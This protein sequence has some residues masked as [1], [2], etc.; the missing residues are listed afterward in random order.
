MMSVGLA[1]C[2]A[3]S[4]QPSTKKAPTPQAV[5]KNSAPNAFFVPSHPTPTPT[6]LPTPTP[7]S[8]TSSPA[9]GT[10]NTAPVT[11]ASGTV[12]RTNVTPLANEEFATASYTLWIPS[13]AST[14]FGVIVWG[15]WCGG[16]D[17]GTGVASGSDA[18][19]GKKYH[20]A[21]LGQSLTH[22]DGTRNCHENYASL[23]SGPAL[24]RALSQFATLSNHAELAKA[25]LVADGMSVT[26]GWV[27]EMIKLYPD[28]VVAGFARGAPTQDNLVQSAIKVPLMLT[29]GEK[30]PFLSGDVTDF[31]QHRALGA[32]WALAT[33]P[34]EG[35]TW[36]SQ[37]TSFLSIYF[38]AVL[39]L[40]LTDTVG[41][42]RSIDTTQEGWLGDNSTHQI[43]A[44]AQYQGNAALKCSWLPDEKSAQAWM[45]M[46]TTAKVS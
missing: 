21:V 2:G 44:V 46:V 14:V 9:T 43:T 40:R 38:D 3:N 18:Y 4:S 7:A 20:L 10:G 15:P 11:D 42:L 6:P 26:A 28:R 37:T 35:H 41:Q 19:L 32:P 25:P 34:N 23:S 36:N 22:K 8:K 17:L 31:N 27:I 12:Y 16:S 24:F 1:G 45:H 33:T 5:A 13:D 29:S 30:D 39:P